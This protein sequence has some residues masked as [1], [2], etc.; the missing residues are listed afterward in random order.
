MNKR[1]AEIVAGMSVFSTMSYIMF[2]NPLI[3]S[4]AGMSAS[5]VFFATCLVAGLG[6]ILLGLGA[7]TPTALAPA[8]GLN[9]FFVEYI[10]ANNLPWQVGLVICA[11]TGFL[12]FLLTVTRWRKRIVDALPQAIIFAVSTAIGT[13]L[14]EAGLRFVGIEPALMGGKARFD[15]IALGLFV[16]GLALL[17][18]F[19]V[20]VKEIARSRQSTSIF[21]VASL[22]PIL[23]IVVLT[24]ICHFFFPTY[25]SPPI[26]ADKFWI[27]QGEI[28][29]L[30]SLVNPQMLATGL[31]MGVVI[32]YVLLADIVGTARN[33]QL[34]PRG[35]DAPA[36]E[37]KIER[38]FLWESAASALSPV[39]GTTPTVCYAENLVGP[40]VARLTRGDSTDRPVALGGLPAVI[41]GGLFLLFGAIGYAAYARGGEMSEIF[42]KIA[43]APT[44]FYIGIYIIAQSLR[45]QVAGV[46]SDAGQLRNVDFTQWVPAAIAITLIPFVRLDYALGLGIVSYFLIAVGRRQW[47]VLANGPLFVFA[48]LAVFAMA[49]KLMFAPDG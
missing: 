21:L 7:G 22:G 3:L 4:G 8:M 17:F 30:S 1:W 19:D 35:D 39:A 24:A 43:I 18:L 27:W 10:K 32:L 29:K 45:E 41:V 11:I 16:L 37:A 47:D 33:P 46:S 44:L 38:A 36:H 49:M 20:V 5:A 31:A 15:K 34:V 42:P 26:R 13:V 25:L 12:F 40:M 14:L 23:S 6:S 2:V 28:E 9:V 48:L